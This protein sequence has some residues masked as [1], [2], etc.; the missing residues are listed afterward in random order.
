MKWVLEEPLRSVFVSAEPDGIY[1]RSTGYD[2]SAYDAV[3]PEALT[4]LSQS[5]PSLIRQLLEQ[6]YAE[7]VEQSLHIPYEKFVSLE[8]GDI[9]AF[10]QLA[11][12]APFFMELSSS[13]TLGSAEFK[14]QVRFYYGS[15][16]VSLEHQGC[17]VKYCDTVYRLD[18]QAYSLMAEVDRFRSLSPSD[19]CS[20]ECLICFA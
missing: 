6:G 10:E 17:F 5:L 1:I 7:I 12:W 2:L 9:H 19:K 20:S 11:P 3:L 8:D 14:Y 18:R 13:G 15:N 4:P 16:R